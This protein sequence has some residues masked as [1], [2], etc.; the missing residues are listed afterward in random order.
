MHDTYDTIRAYARRRFKS[1]RYDDILSRPRSP[2]S[3]KPPQVPTPGPRPQSKHGRE[4]EPLAGSTVHP[5]PSPGPP[6]QL[7]RWQ[8]QLRLRRRG[9]A[10]G[11]RISVQ[12]AGAVPSEPCGVDLGTGTAVG[13]RWVWRRPARF[14]VARVQSE[15]G[16]VVV[17][18]LG[19]LACRHMT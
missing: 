12:R 13:E 3:R 9:I 2:L 8:G 10:L 1:F 16:E 17:A 14:G 11:L 6:R 7:Q 15:R 18:I 4:D 5:G 19:W